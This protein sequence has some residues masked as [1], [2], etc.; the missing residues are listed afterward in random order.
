M[1]RSI[2]CKGLSKVSL[3]ASSVNSAGAT[4]ALRQG[5]HS[6]D[7]ISELLDKCAMGYWD[8]PRYWAISFLSRL[9]REKGLPKSGRP[10]ARAVTRASF[11]CLK[12]VSL[13]SVHSR[14]RSSGPLRAS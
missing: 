5:G 14:G 2:D 1:I 3:E 12:A 7:V 9:K 4:R 11:L 10:K 13:S 6:W 8:S